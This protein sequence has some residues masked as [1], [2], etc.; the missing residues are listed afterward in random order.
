MIELAGED[1]KEYEGEGHEEEVGEPVATSPEFREVAGV[2]FRGKTAV[3]GAKCDDANDTDDYYYGTL[4]DTNKTTICFDRVST[5]YVNVVPCDGG[6]DQE[7]C[8]EKVE[9]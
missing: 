4:L 9:D 6:V 2:R 1:V 8:E 3:D 5:T 7:L